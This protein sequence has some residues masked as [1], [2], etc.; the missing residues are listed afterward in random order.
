MYSTFLKMFILSQ[1]D[2]LTT[3]IFIVFISYNHQNRYYK[4]TIITYKCDF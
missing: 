1:Q 2:E 4:L 3:L